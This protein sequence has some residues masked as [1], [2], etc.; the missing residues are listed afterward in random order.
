MFHCLYN[1][2]S[3]DRQDI[4]N[5]EKRIPI[6]YSPVYSQESAFHALCTAAVSYVVRSVNGHVRINWDCIITTM[7]CIAEKT[8]QTR[9]NHGTVHRNEQG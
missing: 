7:C 1:E 5:T 9:E 3:F 4:Q 6:I 2:L 8:I